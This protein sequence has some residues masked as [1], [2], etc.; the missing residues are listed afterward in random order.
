MIVLSPAPLVPCAAL[1]LSAD[2]VL[3]LKD[4]GLPRREILNHFGFRTDRR[5][6]AN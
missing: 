6:H 2:S 4:F 1:R 5:R 3:S